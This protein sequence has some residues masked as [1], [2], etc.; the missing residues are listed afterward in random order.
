[1][2]FAL[3]K[4]HLKIF[5]RNFNLFAKILFLMLSLATE[6][7]KRARGKQLIKGGS[8][9]N[10]DFCS[11]LLQNHSNFASQTFIFTNT[12]YVVLNLVYYIY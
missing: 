7:P 9:R 3:K 4:H 8:K 1:M 10:N 11:I 2:R 5:A 6:E 12:N